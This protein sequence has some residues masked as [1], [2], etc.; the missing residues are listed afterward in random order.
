MSD[1]AFSLLSLKDV[2]AELIL[3]GRGP[4]RILDGLNLEVRN[5]EWVAVLG[6]TGSGKST[7]ARVCAGLL[8]ASAG[9]IRLRGQP[10]RGATPRVG[11][12][13]Q[14]PALFPWLTVQN[15]IEL[16]LERLALSA[17]D[18]ARRVAWAVDRL[19]LEGY[20]EAYPRELTSG[21]KL[22]VA[23]ARAL[24]TQP[25]LLV[26]DDPFSGLD[27]LT[28]EAVK[29]ELMDLW[30]NNDVNP[31]AIL[32]VTHNIQEALELASRLL[33]LG[34]KPAKV[35]AELAVPLPYPR[36]PESAAFQTLAQR[37]HDLLTERV[38]PDDPT[39]P[40]EG[41]FSRR[42]VPLPKAEMVQIMGLLE[43]LDNLGG[44]F[45]IFDFVADTRQNYGQMLM[46][47]NA[48]EM[49]GL[50]RTPKD[51]VELT[52]LG[53][54]VLEADINRRKALL[55]LQLQGL[56]LIAEVM[57]LIRRSP[58][59]GV[60]RDLVLDW[61][62]LRLPSEQ[63]Y[64][65][66][67]TLVAWCRYAELMGYSTRKG[68]LYLDRLF[69]RDG[70]ELKE[71]P[72]PKPPVRRGFRGSPA[73]ASETAP[74]LAA[75]P[76]PPVPPEEVVQAAEELGAEMAGAAQTQEHPDRESDV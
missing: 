74:A 59:N 64:Q 4:T 56:K 20:E 72:Q 9:E 58:D 39:A 29:D 13:F 63:P 54:T 16:A 66:F 17:E 49:L 22:R 2:E 42:L 38:L 18:K 7:L 51:H 21:S 26:L 35:V 8:P 6:P 34:G 53:R 14:T 37:V 15:N 10:L 71:L 57:E 36:N 28:A 5:D 40:L 50:V 60:S 69:V 12:V 55:N 11:M 32:L 41:R 44:R 46:V 25:D 27:V 45:D 23:V 75:L 24:V 47:V 1:D 30:Q 48:A 62:A 31:K 61:L 76:E 43:A 73:A 70:A 67:N 68:L 65:Q 33:I 19:G 52:A 3:A